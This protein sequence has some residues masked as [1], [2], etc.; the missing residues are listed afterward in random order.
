MGVVIVKGVGLIRSEMFLQF[1]MY[2]DTS[3]VLDVAGIRSTN[4]EPKLSMRPSLET[5]M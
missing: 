2:F 5:S 1:V 3:A 4:Y